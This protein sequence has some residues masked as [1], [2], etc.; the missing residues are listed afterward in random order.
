MRRG[1]HGAMMSALEGEEEEGGG[2]TTKEEEGG[3]EEEGLMIKEEG[4]EE[5][6]EM[7]RNTKEGEGTDFGW[8]PL[9]DHKNHLKSHTHN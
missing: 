4:V 9:G 5:G 2:L 8:G 3:E 6:V 1:C 7:V